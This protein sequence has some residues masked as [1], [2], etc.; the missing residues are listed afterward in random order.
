[1]ID[2]LFSVQCFKILKQLVHVNC[3]LIYWCPPQNLLCGP[4][5]TGDRLSIIFVHKRELTAP[6][7]ILPPWM[8][9]FGI[10]HNFF[11]MVL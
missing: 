11:F 2:S 1:M 9:P 3:H 10:H 7:F 5:Q 4:A 6:V 8:L